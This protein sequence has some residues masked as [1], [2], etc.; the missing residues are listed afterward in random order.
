MTVRTFTDAFTK[1]ALMNASSWQ[2]L[3]SFLF[4]LVR[5]DPLV[6]PTM[7][8]LNHLL[9][10]VTIRDS[11]CPVDSGEKGSYN[12]PVPTNYPFFLV[13]ATQ[14][15]C[16]SVGSSCAW[17]CLFSNHLEPQTSRGTRRCSP[18]IVYR[19]HICSHLAA[20]KPPTHNVARHTG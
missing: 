4:C 16:L 13:D 17:Y 6:G 20:N 15:V 12:I 14:Q 3:L 18:N 11:Y 9:S 8:T 19:S 7:L 5:A 2:A 10:F 1:N